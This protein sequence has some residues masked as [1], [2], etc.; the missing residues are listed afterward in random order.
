MATKPDAENWTIK[1]QIIEDPASGL[2]LLFKVMP[3]GNPRLQIFGDLPLGNREIIFDGNGEEAG[4]GT[5]LTGL[6]RA[7]WIDSVTQSKA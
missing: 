6:C 2:T 7:T 3:D 1:E 5:A 4:A